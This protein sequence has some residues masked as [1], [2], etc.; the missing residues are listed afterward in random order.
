[1]NCGGS[2]ADASGQSE[3]SKPDKLDTSWIEIELDEEVAKNGDPKNKVKVPVPR[4]RYV[5]AA[6]GKHYY[7][8]L[9]VNGR[10][11]IPIRPGSPTVTFPDFDGD[12]VKSA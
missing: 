2:D 12:A 11:R 7:G 6:G 1:M 3:D 4:A 8:T 10:A 9:D 5:V